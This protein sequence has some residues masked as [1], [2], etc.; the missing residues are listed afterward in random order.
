MIDLLRSRRSVRKYQGKPLPKDSVDILKEALL[1]CP[2][3]HGINPWT[4][5]F[6]DDPALLLA[7]AQAKEHGSDF[8]RGA[9]LAIVVCGDETKTDVWVENCSIVAIVA[10]LTA[11]SLGLGSCW[12]QIRNRPHSKEISAEQ[13]IQELLRIPQHLR[14]E[15]VVSVGHPAE[16]PRPVPV[17]SLPKNKI[18]ENR[19]GEDA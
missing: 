15:A 6:V 1:R 3:S 5:L 18:M 13:Y 19:Y 12:I 16:S 2:S 14:V 10:H 7:L 4:L 17:E 9:G 8:V 11:H